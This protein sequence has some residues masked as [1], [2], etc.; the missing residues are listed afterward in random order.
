MPSIM[1]D[2]RDTKLDGNQFCPL[3]FVYLVDI[4]GASSLCQALYEVLGARY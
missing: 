1:L 4:H 2:E 3:L